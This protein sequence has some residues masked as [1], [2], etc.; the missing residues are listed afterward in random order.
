MSATVRPLHPAAVTLPPACD[1]PPLPR[2]AQWVEDEMRHRPAHADPAKRDK[3]AAGT[4]SR[5][6]EI[7]AGWP[8]SS[9]LVK[10]DVGGTSRAEDTW[11]TLPHGAR[12]E[13][14]WTLSTVCAGGGVV[15]RMVFNGTVAAVSWAHRQYGLASLVDLTP[16]QW[17]HAIVHRR[18]H[19]GWTNPGR[20]RSGT[21][22]KSSLNQ[23]VQF[24]ARLQRMVWLHYATEHWWQA[25]IWDADMDPRIPRRPHEP[26]MSKVNMLRIKQ[27]WLREATRLWL[28]DGITRDLI[29]I[30]TAV[31]R[32][33]SI[34][35]L[36][37]FL[38]ERGIDVDLLTADR[39]SLN[40]IARDF[41]VFCRDPVGRG[42]RRARIVGAPGANA[43][44][45][46]VAQLF[47]FAA[48]NAAELRRFTGVDA[49]GRVG[50]EHTSA[51]RRMCARRGE[52]ARKRAQITSGE[53]AYRDAEIATI[54]SRA[55]VLALPECET[56]TYTH[57]GQ[58][59][60]V[61]GLGQEQAYRMLLLQIKTGRRMSELAL[62]D[63]DPLLP[64]LTP[65]PG[66]D[67]A[68]TGGRPVGGVA[69]LRYQQTKIDGS[70]DR[71]VVDQ[72]CVDLVHAQQD[73]VRRFLTEQGSPVRQ[74]RY[75]FVAP[76]QNRHGNRPY[77]PGH[78][79]E[80]LGQ[81]VD[82]ARIHDERDQPLPLT[83][84]HQFRHTVATNFANAGVP[85]YV[86]QRFLGHTTPTMSMHYV[87]IR[88]ETAEQAFLS[89]VK[90]GADGQEVPMDRTTMYDL[91]QLDRGTDRVLPNGLCL[92]PPARQCDKGNACYTC[93]M[94]ATDRS[95]TE[96]HQETLERTR[97]L[98]AHR[99]RQHEQRTGRPMAESN[100]WLRERLQEIT[101]L[102]RIIERLGQ[103]PEDQHSL[104]GG[105]VSARVAPAAPVPIEITRKPRP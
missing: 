105:G 58:H 5:W 53:K 16:Q 56:F 20:R 104:Q 62:M 100:V 59:F 97:T 63:F 15:S 103:L 87:A 98:I 90:I 57:R 55:T 19:E 23:I 1:L 37:V 82:A 85:V 41:A 42:V 47:E 72:E 30:S 8:A 83:R 64:L 39:A 18:E 46:D 102:E 2:F 61:A 76:R 27:P 67:D 6:W 86:L 94:F 50:A 4:D 12:Q 92:L 77:R 93:G 70:A 68:D 13:L 43:V 101:A 71:I 17:A 65:V 25:E 79:Y 38:T 22:E 28:A 9:G 95:F 26:W 36:V 75:L 44:L 99:Q 21:A 10:L 35:K 78:Y 54:L 60:T 11:P 89:L 66:P 84:T 69:W 96:V 88:D 7:P 49:W 3:L 32:H 74:P 24:L 33:N 40:G 51:F 73:W 52:V 34:C 48:D 31:G 14:A 29:R 81:F 91:L 45:N 80:A